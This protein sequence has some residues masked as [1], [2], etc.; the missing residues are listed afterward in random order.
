MFHFLLWMVES[1]ERAILVIIFLLLSCYNSIVTSRSVLSPP[2]GTGDA[3]VPLL[4]CI[5]FN[6]TKSGN[7]IC[8]VLFAA[9]PL[10]VYSAPSL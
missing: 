4:N 1:R 2:C 3:L 8:M 5:F 6:P 10:I 9:T 7:G